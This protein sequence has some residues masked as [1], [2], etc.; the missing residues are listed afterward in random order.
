MNDKKEK[1]II[2]ALSL[3]ACLLVAG[4][5]YF[6]SNQNK[7]STSDKPTGNVIS[8]TEYDGEIPNINIPISYGY[9]GNI[10][11]ELIKNNV[12]VYK[13]KANIVDDYGIHESTYIGVKFLDV[14][15]ALNLKDFKDIRFYS[16]RKNAAFFKN[17]FD[18]DSSFIIFNYDSNEIRDESASFLAVNFDYSHAVFNIERIE[19]Y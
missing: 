7:N 16:E 18:Q 19:V 5:L 17:D 4:I 13:F 2:I 10:N 14:L 11:S 8:I 15:D 12:K 1:I 9:V 6:L 3:V